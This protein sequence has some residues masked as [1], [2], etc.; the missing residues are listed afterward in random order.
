MADYCCFHEEVRRHL[1][2][3][4]RP[5]QHS[6]IRVVSRWVEV[7]EAPA[8]ILSSDAKSNEGLRLSA[9]ELVDI[10]G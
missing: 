8:K 5:P 9:N 4:S 2:S 6:W 1:A 10:I 7:Q 3:L